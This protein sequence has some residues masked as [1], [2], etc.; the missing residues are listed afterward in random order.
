MNNA[1]FWDAT[2]Y[3]FSKNPR[4]VGTY[5]FH[6]QG[7]GDT[8]LR[9]SVLTS[10]TQRHIP[11]DDYSSARDIFIWREYESVSKKDSTSWN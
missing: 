3:D 9:M 4:F 11:E 10:A 2:P 6:H 7:G 5:R 1:A 8:L